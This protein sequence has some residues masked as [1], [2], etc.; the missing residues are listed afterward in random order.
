[1]G[2]II[3]LLVSAVLE[4]LDG[5]FLH[6][7]AS[8]SVM[9]FR[10]YFTQK[11]LAPVRH[12]ESENEPGSLCLYFYSLNTIFSILQML[13]DVSMCFV[14]FTQWSIDSQQFFIKM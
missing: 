14:C 4:H 6:R 11:V 5:S 1:M 9:R 3:V 7:L 2:H 8:N 10:K 12:Q 13:K